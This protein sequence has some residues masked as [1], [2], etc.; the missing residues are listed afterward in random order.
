MINQ[1]PIVR[2]TASVCEIFFSDFRKKTFS[3]ESVL[4]YTSFRWSDEAMGGRKG[5]GAFSLSL[6][7]ISAIPRY[8]P[9]PRF[10][11][12]RRSCRCSIPTDRRI[13]PSSSPAFL[14][15]CLG[16]EAWV[17][18]AGNSTE[19]QSPWMETSRLAL[20]RESFV[21]IGWLLTLVSSR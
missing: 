18:T 5:A 8:R 21:S 9:S 15:S 13:S 7:T 2:Y 20:T 4:T 19:R 16:I 17:M 3:A 1:A 10:R 11:S 14:R 6:R 12:S